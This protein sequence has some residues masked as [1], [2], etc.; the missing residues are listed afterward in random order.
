[1]K[2]VHTGITG[3][4]CQSHCQ[5]QGIKRLMI[6]IETGVDDGERIK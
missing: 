5:G 3:I 4:L 6:G 1:M 2:E